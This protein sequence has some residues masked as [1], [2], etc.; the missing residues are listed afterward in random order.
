MSGTEIESKPKWGDQDEDSG[1][2]DKEFG[3]EPFV[4]ESEPDADGVIHKTIVEYKVNDKGQRVKIVRKI[5]KYKKSVKI[6]AKVERRR[7]W[8]KFGECYSAPVGPE[9]G[10]TSLGDEVFLDFGIIEKSS[11]AFDKG[12]DVSK[13]GIVCRN[14]GKQGDH[15]TLKCPYKD[16]IPELTNQHRGTESEVSNQIAGNTGKYIPP[17]MR[18]GARASTESTDSGRSGKLGRDETATIRVTNLSED[19][20]D[21]DLMEL[22][23]PFGPIS[24]VYLAKDKTSNLSKGFAFINFI[25]RDDAAKAIEKLSGFGYDH[26]IL[27][28][29][30]AK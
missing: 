19:T 14:C 11:N 10:I 6:N 25:H 13:L 27:H 4:T 22:F 9:K 30:W 26:L 2:F 28:L 12:Q 21:S 1:D 7:R 23:R 20:K 5:R 29:E 16:K 3:N 8:R 24:R 15:W 17:S 18:G